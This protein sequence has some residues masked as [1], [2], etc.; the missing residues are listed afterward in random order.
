MLSNDHTV[1]NFM[2]IIILMCIR[3]ESEVGFN[4]LAQFL[5][6]HGH[7]PLSDKVISAYFLADV[8]SEQLQS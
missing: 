3:M 4:Y 7:T 2:L 1:F 8:T 5:G 6:F